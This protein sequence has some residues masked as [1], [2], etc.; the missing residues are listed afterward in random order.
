MFTTTILVHPGY[1]NR[2]LQTWGG[3]MQQTLL[4]TVLEA[5][6]SKIKAL[7]GSLSSE[8]YFFKP[9]SPCALTLCGSLL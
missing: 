7:A 5:G 3:L 6:K 8:A 1:C 4:L 2:K 9:S